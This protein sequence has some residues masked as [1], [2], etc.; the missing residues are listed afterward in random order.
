MRVAGD[1][2]EDLARCKEGSLELERFL[3]RYGHL[4]PGTYDICAHSYSEKPEL[5]LNLNRAGEEQGDLAAAP[6]HAPKSAQATFPSHVASKLRVGARGT[7]K[8]DRTE[9]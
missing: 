8:K 5:Y 4:R 9:P 2:V 6:A 1:F 3:H 7:L